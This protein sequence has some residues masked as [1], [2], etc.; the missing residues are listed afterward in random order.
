MR[1][2]PSPPVAVVV[3]IFTVDDGDLRALLIHRSDEPQQ[4]LWAVPGGRL[5]PGESL[6]G[7][8]VGEG[9]AMPASAA[10]RQLD[11]VAGGVAPPVLS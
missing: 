7:T 1:V 5:K 9:A 4:G 11:D 10:A 8:A 2:P 6:V 3:V